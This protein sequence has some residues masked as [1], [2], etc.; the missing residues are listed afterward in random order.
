[1]KLPMH[2]T[3]ET[4]ERRTPKTH[5]TLVRFGIFLCRKEQARNQ[6]VCEPVI[7]LELPSAHLRGHDFRTLC[8]LCDLTNQTIL[9]LLYWHRILR[10]GSEVGETRVLDPSGS[11]KDE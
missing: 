11:G 3:D 9:Y 4:I 5:T 6:S 7:A 10:N 2:A 1:M 8:M